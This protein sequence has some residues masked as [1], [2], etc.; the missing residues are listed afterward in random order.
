MQCMSLEGFI[1][2]FYISE[3]KKEIYLFYYFIQI[4]N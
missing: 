3:M 1:F 2:S 4:R